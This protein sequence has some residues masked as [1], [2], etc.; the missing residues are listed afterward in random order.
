[1]TNSVLKL[2][3][4]ERN[5]ETIN[6][7][8]ISGVVDC[9]GKTAYMCTDEFTSKSF[10]LASTCTCTCNWLSLFGPM[11]IPMTGTYMYTCTC[12]YSNIH[13]RTVLPKVRR[14][15]PNFMCTSTESWF[16]MSY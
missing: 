8:L 13:V 10:V 15:T 6:T 2:I 9:Y 4:Q 1:M 12:K 5:G 16:Y 14:C 7:R 11:I 3:E